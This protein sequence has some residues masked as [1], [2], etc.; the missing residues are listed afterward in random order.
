MT[1]HPTIRAGFGLAVFCIATVLVEYGNP[2]HRPMA[3]VLAGGGV[4]CMVSA[5]L[6]SRPKL[7]H[8]I[9]DALDAALLRWSDSD[10][11]TVRDLLSGGA[12]IFGRTGSGKTSS[13]GKALA[14]AIVGYGNSGGLI[15]AAKPEDTDMWRRIFADAGR[16]DDLLIFSPDNPTPLRFNFLAYEMACGG[17]TRNITRCIT[18]IGETLRSSSD[19]A[20]GENADFWQREQ[21]RLIFNAVEVVKLATGKVS[22]PE[23][24]RFISTAA[25]NPLQI[26]SAEWQSQFHN[27][28]LKAAWEKEKSPIEQHDFELAKE[29]WLGEFPN[30]ADK[31]RSSILTG[32]LG[33]L[34]VF[35]T[36]V[37]R[38]LVSTTTNVTPD[39]MFAGKWVLIDMAPAEWGDIGNFVCAGWKYLCQR[40]VLRRHATDGDA[41]NVIWCD[42][43]QLFTNSHDAH[44]IAQCRSHK[45]CMVFLTQSLHSYYSAMP[46]ETGRH[47]ADALLTNFHHKVFHALGDVQTAEMASGLIG[48]ELR[49]F[50]GGSM[51]PQENMMDELM[52]R[53]QY[54]GSFN[55]HF[56]K[57]LQDNVFING[58]RTGGHANGLLCDCIV[59]RSGEPFASGQN[60]LMTSFS[61]RG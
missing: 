57:V 27:Q 52:G 17:H 32:V 61:Q 34:H 28:I 23:L 42:E 8:K 19:S 12:A 25:M 53:S 36:G 2:D 11:F 60:Y 54:T 49:T 58:L 24:Q 37:V 33:I 38:E 59:V 46:G 43:A 30:M 16:A 55:Q 1:I 13:S 15:L 6:T 20:S 35:N 50:I 40:A 45:G 3:L 7:H 10:L 39:D 56:E 22:A 9:R 4:L 48:K 47:H 18:T 51:A 5:L 21:E 14:K 44:Y 41:I 31:T 26:G 29:F